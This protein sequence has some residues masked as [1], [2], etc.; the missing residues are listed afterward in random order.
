MVSLLLQSSL[1]VDGQSRRRVALDR[2]TFGLH[3][4][5]RLRAGGMSGQAP[6]YGPFVLAPPLTSCEPAF[7]VF[8]RRVR[9]S[10]SRTIDISPCSWEQ[11]QGT[12][13]YSIA[14]AGTAD[15]IFTALET[16]PTQSRA[17][18]VEWHVDF[19][20]GA[21]LVR[22]QLLIIGAAAR[23]DQ[24]DLRA[25]FCP[26]RWRRTACL[27]ALQGRPTGSRLDFRGQPKKSSS[28]N[29]AGAIA[30]GIIGAVVLALV[31]LTALWY[32]RRARRRVAMQAAAERDAQ[33]AAHVAI[34]AASKDDGDDDT[35][36]GDGAATVVRAGT[37]N[38]GAV[39]FT[40]D[41]L[42][43]LRAIDRPPAYD[44]PPPPPPPVPA[45]LPGLLSA[46]PASSATP[47]ASPPPPPPPPLP[48]PN[49]ADDEIRELPCS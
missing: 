4:L 17:G 45:N 21:N 49:R 19:N 28:S 41:S 26:D 12:P 8:V 5:C 23:A 22:L 11:G 31:V 10:L 40:E 20:A 36:L 34:H 2:P 48:L 38:L 47:S 29:H 25:D 27:L 39:R 44:R 9:L 13:P 37:F 14:V 30:G 32:V 18:V 24:P 33:Y 6:V 3:P 43:H 15:A 42:D 7:L 16:L 1:A 46:A 35:P